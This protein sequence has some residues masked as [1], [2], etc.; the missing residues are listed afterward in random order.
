MAEGPGLPSASADLAR[1]LWEHSCPPKHSVTEQDETRT[2]DPGAQPSP[3]AL[4][5][6]GHEGVCSTQL[7]TCGPT[8]TH[9]QVS[10]QTWGHTL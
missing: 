10:P 2:G 1:D 5:L 9:R 3:G 6:R 7:H 8:G 4:G